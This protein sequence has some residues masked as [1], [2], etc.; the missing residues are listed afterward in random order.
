MTILGRSTKRSAVA[1]PKTLELKNWARK[2]PRRCSLQGAL[3]VVPA[4]AA[5]PVVF[6]DALTTALEALSRQQAMTLFQTVLASWAA[7]LV[8]LVARAHPIPDRGGHHRRLGIALQTDGEAVLQAADFEGPG[9]PRHRHA[10]RGGRDGVANQGFSAISVSSA[11][12]D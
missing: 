10:G 9:Q 6:D 11:E 3:L 5:V 1:G 2:A 8:R 12:R 4:G 7:V